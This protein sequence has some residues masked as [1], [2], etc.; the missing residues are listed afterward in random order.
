MTR[1][2]GRTIGLVFLVGPRGSGKSTVGR[3]LADRVGWCFADA[4]VCLEERA[5]KSIREIFAAEGEPGF[6]ERE[7]ATLRELAERRDHVIATGGGVVLR[8]ENRERM[9]SHGAVVY[10]TAGVDVLWE[11]MQSDATT[12]ERRPALAGGG[13]E[14]VAQVVAAREAVYR[15]C[16]HLVVS[17]EGKTPEQIAEEIAGWLAAEEARREMASPAPPHGRA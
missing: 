1:M 14:E 15:S 7:A 11:R 6:R 10:L 5:G 4:D 12:A 9:A 8:E 16:A 2:G 17:T 3:L 13:R